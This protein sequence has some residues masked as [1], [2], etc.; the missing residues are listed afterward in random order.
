MMAR[1]EKIAR[2]A[3]LAVIILIIWQVFGYYSDSPYSWIEIEQPELDE[4]R[5]QSSPHIP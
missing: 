1:S 5:Q 3:V 2:W 4:E